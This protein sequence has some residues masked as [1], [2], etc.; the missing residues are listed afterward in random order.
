MTG[1]CLAA[2]MV[3]GLLF[4]WMSGAVGRG[5][6]GGVVEEGIRMMSTIAMVMIVASGFAAVLRESGGVA[7]L[8]DGMAAACGGSKPVAA[9]LM[10]CTGTVIAFTIGSSFATIPVVS[11]IYVPLCASIGFSP[12]ATAAI[13]AFSAVPGDP[14]SP[15]SNSTLGASS[16]L[17]VDGQ[18][19]HMRDCVIPSI[20]H[21]ALPMLFGGW[22][23]AMVL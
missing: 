6:I 13:V 21:C 1:N 11:A 22:L 2:A 14:A 16:G 3:S 7:A 9:A 23:A 18:F 5:E 12:A 20:L 8:V 17:A 19:D 15:L 4:L 10:L